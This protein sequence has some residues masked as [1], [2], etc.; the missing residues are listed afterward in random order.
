MCRFN[1]CSGHPSTQHPHPPSWRCG[2][3]EGSSV[4]IGRPTANRSR[5]HTRGSSNLPPSA[6]HNEH[7][8]ASGLVE[9][10][11]WKRCRS[12][13]PALRGSSPRPSASHPWR[14]Q[15]IG[16]GSR[17]ESGQGPRVPVGVRLP[18]SP[19]SS[20][21]VSQVGAAAASKAVRGRTT[22]PLAGSIPVP[23]AGRAPRGF[24]PC[25]V[26]GNTADSGSAVL[27]SIPGRAAHEHRLRSSAGQS[28]TLVRYDSAGSNPAEGSQYLRYFEGR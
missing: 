7:W 24:L 17:L 9:E 18:S 13:K 28:G 6:Q 16:S 1:S 2:A 4:G 3:L 14:C 5:G 11:R 19:R 27:G 12:G 23:S 20:W 15:P 26:T 25:G 21:K 22:R 8:K 10:H